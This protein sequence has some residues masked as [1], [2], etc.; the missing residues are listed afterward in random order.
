MTGL[1]R[2]IADTI[3]RRGLFGPGDRV[4]VALSGGSDSV[5][6][7]FALRDLA[8][9]GGAPLVGLIHVNHQLR[10]EEAEADEQF[11]RQLAARLALPLEIERVDVAARARAARQSL[12]A[13]ARDLRYACLGDA[14]DRLGASVVA[15]GHTLDDQAETV[16][17][18][19]LRG[20]GSRGLGGIRPRRGRFVRP[21][22]DRTRA[23]LRRDL[24]RRGEAFCE[25]S[26]NR[27]P[28]IPRNRIRHE[29]LPVIRG[30]APGGLR[31]LAR[32]A[33]HAADDETFLTRAAIEMLSTLVLSSEAG[34]IIL[35]A[36]GTARL[37]AAI[38]RRVVRQ[39]ASAAAPGAALSSRHLDAVLDMARADSSRGHLDLPGLSLDRQGDALT[40]SAAR[41]PL[42]DGR[43]HGT[44]GAFEVSDEERGLPL[45]GSVRL[46]EA[47]VTITAELAASPPGRRAVAA[48]GRTAMLQAASLTTRSSCVTGERAI[49]SGHLG[50]PGVASYRTCSSI[51]RC[52][53]TSGISCP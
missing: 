6:L 12:E 52:R 30:I 38:S 21:L 44:S 9:A 15:T 3:R 24:E 19:L 51:E 33:S 41:A 37:P 34:R 47:G 2:H 18:R 29:L 35:S 45:P 40:V 26:S 1:A 4:A 32:L 13:A 16:L 14:A 23:E 42:R 8:A 48:D 36:A 53:A 39:A 11:C 5:A 7:V 31:A 49:G 28:A 17:L 27:S 20:A 46:P 10:G 43:A 25:D 22:I 50:R